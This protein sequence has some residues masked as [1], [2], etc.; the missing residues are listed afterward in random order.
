ML[1]VITRWTCRWTNWFI[2]KFVS[3][4]RNAKIKL[5]SEAKMFHLLF[6]HLQSSIKFAARVS[7][8]RHTGNDLD[9]LQ[10]SAQQKILLAMRNMVQSI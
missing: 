2:I 5:K 8:K 9:G 6:L 7:I 4:Y 1:A 3:A 10:I